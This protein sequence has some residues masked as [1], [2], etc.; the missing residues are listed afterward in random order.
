M[1]PQTGNI[2]QAKAED[3]NVKGMIK[4]SFVQEEKGITIDVKTPVDIPT[5]VGVP[6]NNTKEIRVNG[7]LIWKQGAY[8]INRVALAYEDDS[9]THIKFLVRG[10]NYM[11]QSINH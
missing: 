10:G 2:R 1:V 7:T 4:S 5:V 6:I 11:F 8:R 9:Q 3:K